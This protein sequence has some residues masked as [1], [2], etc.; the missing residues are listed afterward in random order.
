M[1]GLCGCVC[2]CSAV[3]HFPNVARRGAPFS[4]LLTVFWHHIIKRTFSKSLF[5]CGQVCCFFIN[6]KYSVWL[7]YTIRRVR[8]LIVLHGLRR[9]ILVRLYPAYTHIKYLFISNTY[10]FRKLS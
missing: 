5:K 7:H 9:E 6:R 2:I 4:R 3:A 8:A 1:L 10:L